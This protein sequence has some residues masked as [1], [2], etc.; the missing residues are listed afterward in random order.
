[1]LEMSARVPGENNINFSY[2]AIREGILSLDLKPGQ[3]LNVGELSEALQVSSTPIKNALWKLQQEHL[4][5]LIPQVGT[6]VSKINLELVEEAANMWFDLEKE[7][8]K[9]AC[10]AY[11]KES[12][13][14]LK[15][16]LYFQEM[17]LEQQ[18]NLVNEKEFVGEFCKLDE[19][20]H[21]I[22]FDGHGRNTTWKAVSYMASDYQRMMMLK[23]VNVHVE[24]MVE[25]HKEII[26]IIE[27]KTIE[28]VETVLK[29]HILRPLDGWR[30]HQ[31]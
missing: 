11:P 14:Q 13:N 10:Q 20:F 15:R 9:A 21:S 5:D 24:Q 25:E 12:L 8:L 6:Y 1:M 18:S 29:S 2:R 19:E 27:N 26:S 30:Q 23:Q 22:I 31:K 17:L 7:C 16:N 3:L 28:Q 4:V